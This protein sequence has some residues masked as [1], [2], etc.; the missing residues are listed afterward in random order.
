[1][2]FLHYFHPKLQKIFYHGFHQLDK[3]LSLENAIQ[4]LCQN[5]SI[6]FTSQTLIFHEKEQFC[7]ELILQ[8]FKTIK[9][10]FNEDSDTESLV[11][12]T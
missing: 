7:I 11:I 1:M 12:Q 3:S 2:I 9:N 4:Q 8:K 6:S 10:I 5:L